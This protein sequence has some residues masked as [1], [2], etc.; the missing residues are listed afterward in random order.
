MKERVDMVGIE[1]LSGVKVYG[2]AEL[3]RRGREE[4]LGGVLGI[5]SFF[6]AEFGYC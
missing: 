1:I 6:K 2:V 5:T 4:D 3:R